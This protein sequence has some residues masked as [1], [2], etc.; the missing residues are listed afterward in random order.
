MADATLTF[1]GL[2]FA[3]AATTTLSAATPAKASGTTA[4]L[5]G[6]IS[7]FTASTS[8][9]LTYNG[10]QT[11]MFHVTASC[12]IST[13]AG[14]ETVD[15]HLYKNG[16]TPLVTI[17]RE[18]SNNDIGAASIETLVSLAQND[19]VEIWLTSTGGDD[20]K[21]DYGQMI[22]KVVG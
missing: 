10:T 5:G 17:R 1:G 2:Y 7:G 18:V 9:R 16:S 8:N 15:I 22:A 14:A 3:T 6:S 12:S 19:Y 21:V 4:Q 11:R 20:V 13:V